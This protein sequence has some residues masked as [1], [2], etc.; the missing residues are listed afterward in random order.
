LVRPA[1]VR[2][3]RRRLIVVGIAGA[4]ALSVAGLSTIEPAQTEIE[5]IQST[6]KGVGKVSGKILIAYASRKGSTAG[7][8]DEIGKQ[9]AASG[10]SVDVRP[11]KDVSD[12]GGYGAVVLGSAINGGKWL[13]EAVK[14][15]QD[16]QSKLSRMPTA[17][18]L[19]CMMMASPKEQDRAMVE[20]Y[21]DPIRALVKPVAEARFAGALDPSKHSF[22][23]GIGLR[24]FLS[25]LKVS[26]GDYR[27]WAAVRAWADSTRPLLIS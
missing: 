10:A 12:L 27:D 8:A 25:Y 3:G 21:L 15:V 6:Y 23:K 14:F 22:V 7:V 19:V 11:M 20:P 9:L 16:N 13:P 2:I 26:P 18:F 17:L 24:F 4:G 5:P 1:R